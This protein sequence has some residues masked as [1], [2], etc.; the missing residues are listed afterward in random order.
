[1]PCDWTT[2]LENLRAAEEGFG[3]VGLFLRA[4]RG[5]TDGEI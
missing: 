2:P 1:L 4:T 3:R 5:P